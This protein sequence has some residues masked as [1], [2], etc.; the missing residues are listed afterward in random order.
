MPTNEAGLS[1]GHDQG[2]GGNTPASDMPGGEQNM[3]LSD[4]PAAAVQTQP[5]PKADAGPSGDPE[6]GTGPGD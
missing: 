3:G 2:D 5:E 1:G 4:K 6:A